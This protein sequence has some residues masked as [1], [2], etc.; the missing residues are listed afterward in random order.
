MTATAAAVVARLRELGLTVAT[1]ESLTGGLVCGALTDVPGASSV[2]R[3][4]VVAYAT[5]VK[6]A[7][8]GVD[9]DLLRERGAVDEAVARAMAAGARDILRADVGVATTG[10]AGPERSD[11][12]PVGT[13]HVAVDA[14]DRSG[15]RLLALTGDRVAIRRATV[16]VALDLLLTVLAQPPGSPRARPPR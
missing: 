4:G 9:L 2:V 1:A 5:A 8:L 11:G 7:V 10:V 3:G 13:V 6:A 12:Q 16:G 14:G 15:H